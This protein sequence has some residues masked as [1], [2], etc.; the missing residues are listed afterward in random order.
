MQVVISTVSATP[1]VADLYT[2]LDYLVDWQGFALHLPGII[3][4][5]VRT[6]EEDKHGDIKGQK[7]ILYQKWLEVCL[8][9]SW[10]D[11]IKALEKVRQHT[12]AEKVRK[13]TLQPISP[14]QQKK[15]RLSH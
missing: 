15:V 10:E 6:I 14:Q 1:T 7:I 12:I 8:D 9:A 11:V 3:L 5:Q 2:L 4:D 13:A